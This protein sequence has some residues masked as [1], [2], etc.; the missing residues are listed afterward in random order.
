MLTDAP[1]KEAT[2][3]LRAPSEGQSI[4]ADFRSTGLSLR[5]HPVAL[6]RD[7]LVRRNILS[8]RQV[9]ESENGAEVRFVGLVTL[10]Q[11]P[12]TA[13]HTT[14]MTLEDETGIVQVIVWNQVAQTYRAAFLGASL[15]EIRGTF[16]HESSVKNVVALALFDHTRWLG[17]LR[18]PSRDFH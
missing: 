12:S 5:R 16:Q 3:L 4:L 6:L 7:R 14:F 10:R 2:P 17:V 11:S 18:V 9:L 8:A 15:L 13:K 1:P